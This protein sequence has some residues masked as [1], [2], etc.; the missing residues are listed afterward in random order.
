MYEATS[1]RYV[2]SAVITNVASNGGGFHAREGARVEMENCFVD[3][4]IADYGGGVYEYEG[5]LQLDNVS[6]RS[7]ESEQQGAGIYSI[8]GNVAMNNSTLRL[9]VDHGDTGGGALYTYGSDVTI[10]GSIFEYNATTS[11]GGAYYGTDG[12]VSMENCNFVGNLAGTGGAISYSGFN[13]VFLLNSIARGNG[14]DPLEG[15]CLVDYSNIEGGGWPGPGNIDAN[16]GFISKLGYGYVLPGNSSSMDA[17]SGDA[18]G[19]NWCAVSTKYCRNNDA[20]ADMGAYGGPTVVG[21]MGGGHGL[22]VESVSGVSAGSADLALG[23]PY[24]G[25]VPSDWANYA[26]RIDPGGSLTLDL[27]D[28]YLVD[29]RGIDLYVEEVDGEDGFGTDSYEVSVGTTALAL[30]KLGTGTGDATFDIGGSLSAPLRYVKIEALDTDVEID[31]IS[32]IHQKA[33]WAPPAPAAN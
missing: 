29:E 2:N 28:H 19:L 13:P 10:R 4:N 23:A 12:L 22:E 30:T 25:Q 16:P 11:A 9:N 3:Q 1:T 5:I 33:L 8:F 20:T 15:D 14:I 26:V 6:L 18:D 17:G 32:V 24:R 27:G 31:G 7:N 21:W